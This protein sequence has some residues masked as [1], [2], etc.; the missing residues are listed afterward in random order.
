MNQIL[1]VL[2]GCYRILC[3]IAVTSMSACLVQDY[4]LRSGFSWFVP[5]P[6]RGEEPFV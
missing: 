5:L 3:G 1:P 2:L 4:I 6:D